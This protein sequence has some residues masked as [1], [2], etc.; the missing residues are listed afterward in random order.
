MSEE[1][2]GGIVGGVGNAITTFVTDKDILEVLTKKHC[3]TPDMLLQGNR[4]FVCIP[5]HKLD[6]YKELLQLI[7]SQ[8]L[9]WFEQLK[10][11]ETTPVLFVLDEFA[12]L[13]RYDRLINGL[14]TLRSKKVTIMIL[15]QSISQLDALYGGDNRK[16]MVD[17][18]A[19]KVILNASDADSQE[20]FSRIVGKYTSH[21][22]SYTRGKQSSYSISEQELPIIK[23]EAFTTLDEVILLSPYGLQRIK[24]NPYYKTRK[25]FEKNG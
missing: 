12:R 18:C 4:I 3:I 13:G 2:L 24:K 8:F 20:Y 19:Y 9:R 17:N 1:T 10:D 15:T 25:I 23:P 11:E 22:R 6:V 7:I 21:K 16:V 14:A 5:E